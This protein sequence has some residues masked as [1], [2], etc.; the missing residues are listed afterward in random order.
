[1]GDGYRYVR[2]LADCADLDSPE[3]VGGKAVGLGRLCRLHLPVPP[4]FAVGLAAYR[5]FLTRAGLGEVIEDHLSR[6]RDPDGYRIASEK[7][8]EAS[9]AHPGRRGAGDPAG[10][11]TLCDR[12]GAEDLPV[13]VRSSATL[14]DMADALVRRPA[15]DL[16]VGDGRRPGGRPR[17]GM[18]GQ[19]V[20]PPGDRLP[21]ASGQTGRSPGNGCG[22]PAD[23]ASHR[24]RRDDHPGSGDRGSIPGLDRGLSWVGRRGGER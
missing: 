22:R 2:W 14:E 9:A 15:G 7:I 13:A 11:P 6:A 24:R 21:I 12:C 3:E 8:A 20:H 17:G 1:M 23:G 18:L 19:S 16:P 4:G 5:D 10:V